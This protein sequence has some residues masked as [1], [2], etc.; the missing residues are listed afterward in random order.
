MG[1][2][3][4]HLDPAG[5]TA[6]TRSCPTRPC[7]SRARTPCSSR[8]RPARRPGETQ[9]VSRDGKQ[10]KGVVYQWARAW[11]GV[12]S[13]PGVGST[14]PFQGR[15]GMAGDGG[16]REGQKHLRL[17]AVAGGAF[18]GGDARAL[19]GAAHEVVAARARRGRVRAGGV[20]ERV[21]G[22]LQARREVG[23]ARLLVVRRDGARE[24]GRRAGAAV[25][26]ARAREAAGVARQ[27]GHVRVRARHARR[28]RGRAAL[29]VVAGGARLWLGGA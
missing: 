6:G 21:L 26:A 25:V 11:G 17:E 4:G 22:A 20:G 18:A 16:G 19:G 3:D 27:H 28:R 14:R 2:E 7:S 8:R 5:G 10:R 23:L 24:R 15:G 1:R 13:I 12:G 29:A 9:A